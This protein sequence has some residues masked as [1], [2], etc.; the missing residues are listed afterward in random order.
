M[1]YWPTENIPIITYQVQHKL[2]YS[3]P[4]CLSQY[5]KHRPHH[6]LLLEPQ[7]AKN[8]AVQD[9]QIVLLDMFLKRQNPSI[10]LTNSHKSQYVLEI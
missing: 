4:A 1:R 10:H 9:V 7:N 6:E 3:L 5:H 2:C 8:E